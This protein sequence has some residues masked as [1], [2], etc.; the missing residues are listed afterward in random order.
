MK[1][2]WDLRMKVRLESSH[3]S[4]PGGMSPGPNGPNRTSMGLSL[5]E[6]G[7]VYPFG[8]KYIVCQENEKISQYL[9][10]RKTRVV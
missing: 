2:K 6:E 5:P 10:P 4:S 7:S 3:P 9:T 8:H 1:T